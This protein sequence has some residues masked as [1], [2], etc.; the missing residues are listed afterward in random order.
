MNI[1]YLNTIIV[2]YLI[3]I[4]THEDISCSVRILNSKKL[5]KGEKA[6]ENIALSSAVTLDKYNS[7]TFNSVTLEQLSNRFVQYLDVSE[8]SVKSYSV[9]VRKFL[10][11]LQRNSIAQPTR[12][13]VISYKREI[14]AKYAASTVALYLSS[15]R[16]FFAWCELEGLYVDITRGVKSPKQ[17]HEHKRDAFTG[18]ELKKI[19]SS[20]S[21]ETLEDKRN[22]AMFALIAACGLRTVEVM[23]AD[24]GDIHS[25]GGVVMLDVQGKGHSS[26]DSFVK[27]SEPVQKA[28]TEYLSARGHVS[29]NEP[30]FVSC[31]R[32]NKGGR[33]TTRTI[34]QVCKNAMIHAGYNSRRLTAHSLRHS[35]VTIA[36]LQGLS[37]DDVSAFAR[38]SSVSI[39]MCY[40]HSLNRLKS[41]CECAVSAAIF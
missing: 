41:R 10:S 1:K 33:L 36:L 26:K 17:T 30:L 22:Y 19:L 29:E 27:L 39:T 31:S 38:H 6:M 35:A 2:Q 28:I 9:G 7:N 14:S 12:D 21:R 32:R 37:L 15:I 11:F 13:T 34:S 20:M 40:N 24:V 8:Q 3:S 4:Y 23:R 18:D 5:K 16:R 25:V